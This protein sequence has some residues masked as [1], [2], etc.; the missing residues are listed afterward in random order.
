M[1]REVLQQALDALKSLD[2]TLLFTEWEN[3][4]GED[5]GPQL[6]ESVNALRADLTKPYGWQP[7]ESAPKDGAAILVMRDI[8][9]GTKTGHA[10]VCNGHNTYVSM[11]WGDDDGEWTCYMDAVHDPRCPI[12]PTHWMPLPA[13]P[14]A[15][16]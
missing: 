7:I 10:K 14:T 12:E 2:D 1:S 15:P 13:T 16:E 8:W 6:R 9:P 4:E 3:G 11:W 5:I